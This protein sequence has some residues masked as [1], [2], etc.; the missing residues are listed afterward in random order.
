MKSFILAVSIQAVALFVLGVGI[1]AVGAYIWCLRH[2]VDFVF[3]KYIHQS[4]RYGLA[5]S[6]PLSLLFMFIYSVF[7][8]KNKKK[9]RR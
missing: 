6:V 4:I 1:R 7:I 8:F 9:T 2:G 3:N 5:L